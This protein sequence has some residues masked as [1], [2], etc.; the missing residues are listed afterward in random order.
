MLARNMFRQP[1]F[2]SKPTL[3]LSP[4]LFKKKST[5]AY[6]GWMLTQL[7]KS[8][9]VAPIFTATPNPYVTSAA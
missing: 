9:L 3:Q 1:I 5:S 6:E 7:S 8:F 4:I 2:P